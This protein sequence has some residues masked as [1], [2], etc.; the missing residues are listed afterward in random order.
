MQK[1]VWALALPTVLA[2]S[3]CF[4]NDVERAAAGAGIGAIAAELTDNDVLTGAAV[5]AGIGALSD[6]IADA[7]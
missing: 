3:G 7:F 2:L 1:L 6:D 4:E 5:G